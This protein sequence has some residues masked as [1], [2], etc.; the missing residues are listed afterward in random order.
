MEIPGR[1][2]T[3]WLHGCEDFD[4]GRYWHAHEA[5][6]GM[7]LGLKSEGNLMGEPVRG[8]IQI[9]AMLFQHER[10]RVRGIVNLWNKALP[11]LE[12]WGTSLGHVDLSEIIKSDKKLANLTI[13]KNR[14]SGETGKA[15]TLLYDLDT[16]CLSETTPDVLDDY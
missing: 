10:G 5:W 16:G 11:R 4:A 8:L 15:C 7:W 2:L 3:E 14:F 12:G 1:Y 6:E 9:A 13:L